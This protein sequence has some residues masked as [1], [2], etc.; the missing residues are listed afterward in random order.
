M[1]KE[2]GKVYRQQTCSA[3]AFVDADME[4]VTANIILR[5]ITIKTLTDKHKYQKGVYG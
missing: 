3:Y 1:V 5:K 2:Q 4:M